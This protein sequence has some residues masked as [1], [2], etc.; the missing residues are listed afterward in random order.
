MK[1]HLIE[2]QFRADYQAGIAK[3][4][5]SANGIECEMVRG[6]MEGDRRAYIMIRKEDEKL[7]RQILQTDASLEKKKTSIV[8]HASDA[9][10]VEATPQH[11]R[12]RWKE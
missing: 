9:I 1:K 10:G 4:M 5:L 12:G 3:D 6:E 7:A 11:Q 2:I 8:E